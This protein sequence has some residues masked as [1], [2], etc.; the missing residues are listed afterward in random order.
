MYICVAKL[1]NY[2]D[3][4][5]LH[6]E[7]GDK[8]FWLP[9]L[10]ILEWFNHSCWGSSIS[11]WFRNK[12]PAI[13]LCVINERTCKSFR[14]KLII[15]DHEVHQFS[16][17][18]L[19]IDHIS[20]LALAEL[21]TKFKVEVD[22]VLLENGWNH[23]VFSSYPKVQNRLMYDV[24]V[25]IGLHVFKQNSSME[26]I[27]F[28]NPKKEYRLVDKKHS[29]TQFMEQQQNLASLEPHMGEGRVSLSLVPPLALN[30]TVNWGSNAMAS[31]Q[32]SSTTTVQGISFS[33][34]FTKKL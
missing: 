24:T 4:Q 23:V 28:T 12:F 29:Q 18:S 20:I 6:K 10:G 19:D 33:C 30:D 17:F 32:I 27:R 22:D 25:Q 3:K 14:P 34:A 15:N 26:D 1:V 2:H 9:M 21:L 11:F 16:E 13:S 8:E 5:D 7:C 31:N